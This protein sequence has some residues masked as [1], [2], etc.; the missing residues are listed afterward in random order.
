MHNWGD[1]GKEGVIICK[2]WDNVIYVGPLRCQPYDDDLLR[3]VSRLGLTTF[4]P[5]QSV[6][7]TCNIAVLHLTS[8][9]A[10]QGVHRV[11]VH[12]QFF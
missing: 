7:T 11:H 10:K 9:V 8:G 1:K 3:C 12:P 4:T 6:Q 2:I 5:V